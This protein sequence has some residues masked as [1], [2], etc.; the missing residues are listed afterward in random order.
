MKTFTLPSECSDDEKR[1][2][3]RELSMMRE[4]QACENIIQLEAVY[5]DD[6]SVKMVLHYAR[7][8]SL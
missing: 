4:L 5:S 3:L 6:K 7:H 2:I 1:V 8:G